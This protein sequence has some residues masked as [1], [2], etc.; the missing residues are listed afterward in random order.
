MSL[1]T[2]GTNSSPEDL[3]VS[4]LRFRLSRREQAVVLA[5]LLSPTPLTARTVAKRT[6]LAY[7]HAKAVARTLVAWKIL[8]RTPAGLS[9]Q[10]DS[11]RWGP[12][13]IP[14]ALEKKA[15]AV[16]ARLERDGLRRDPSF[17]PAF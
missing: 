13:K 1:P 8:T 12:P 7:S 2:Q 5:I 4:L 14:L 9:F 16:G 6:R 3:L 10:P 17:K 15:G 11:T